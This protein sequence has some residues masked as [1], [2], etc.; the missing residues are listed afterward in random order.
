VADNH[1][2]NLTFH[3]PFPFLGSFRCNLI[4]YHKFETISNNHPVWVKPIVLHIHQFLTQNFS[5]MN[6]TGHDFLTRRCEAHNIVL[7][8]GMFFF[9]TSATFSFSNFFISPSNR[10]YPFDPP[11][12]RLI[13]SFHAVPNFSSSEIIHQNCYIVSFFYNPQMLWHFIYDF[14]VPLCSFIF[15]TE[16]IIKKTE[17]HIFMVGRSLS[18]FN[19][20]LN[21]I[22]SEPILS[23]DHYSP[24]VLIKKCQ[25]GLPKTQSQPSFFR[26]HH[27][28]L[29]HDYNFSKIQIPNFREH[30]FQEL[31]LSIPRLNPRSPIIFILD[32][33]GLNRRFINLQILINDIRKNCSFC[34]VKTKAFDKIE[35]NEQMKQISKATVF[36]GAHG[37]GLSNCIWMT[38][39]SENLKSLI[40]EIIPPGYTCRKWYQ[41]AASISGVE[42]SAVEGGIDEK[43]SINGKLLYCRKD[44]DHCFSGECHDFLRDQNLTINNKISSLIVQAVWGVVK[45]NLKKNYK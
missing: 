1:S 26:S 33:S 3:I 17:R 28:I 10:Q 19:H 36:I 41:S 21:S 2:L 12:S 44:P 4:C 24:S 7:N 40:L 37:S 29:Q 16:G 45:Q 25:I 9:Q 20:L 38:K 18:P 13:G 31:N 8:R 39:S 42:H 11:D 35:L 5:Q 6:C 14:L 30:F 23:I 15:N 32:R 34:K 43:G 22:T 27:D